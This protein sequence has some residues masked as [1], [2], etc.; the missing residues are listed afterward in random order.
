MLKNDLIEAANEA[1][2]LLKQDKIPNSTE[3]D[4]ILETGASKSNKDSFEV[5]TGTT[6]CS[7]SIT[8]CFSG[9]VISLIDSVPSE[10]G[11]VSLRKLD[12]MAKWDKIR[13]SEATGAISIGWLQIDNQC[14][15]APFPVA[16]SPAS[17]EE[18]TIGESTQKENPFIGIG[19][20]LA[21]RH[22]SNIM[23]SLEIFETFSSRM[24]SFN[25]NC[26]FLHFL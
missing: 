23:V 3:V 15:N 24:L 2:S 25:T 6:N 17:A 5:G 22:K 4:F 20:V 14:P 12:M 10:I 9:F 26:C 18:E 21:P 16:L 8:A 19:V 13:A 7:Y 1:L 11:V